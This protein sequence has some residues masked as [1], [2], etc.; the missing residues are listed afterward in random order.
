MKYRHYPVL[1]S[2]IALMIYLLCQPAAWAV[3]DTCPPFYLRTDTGE[4]INPMTGEN[5][6]QPFS[7]RQTCGA[8][9]DVDTISKGYHFMMDWDKAGD[10]RYA[11]TDTPW[12]VSTGLTGSLL[13][14]GFFQLAKKQNTHPDQID[15]SAFDFVARVPESK[16]GF[17]KPGCAACHAGGGLLEFD[18]DGQ[19]YDRRLA[20]N[21]ELAD[22]LDGDY[23]QS[24]W[25]KTGV[26]EPDCF[27]CHGS[28]YH[29]QKRIT[30]IKHL[31]FKWAG[32]AAAGIGQVH[33]R[34]S[35]GEVPVVVY[36]KRLFNEDGTFYLPDMVFRPEAKNCLICHESIEL[37]KRGN[38]WADPLNPDVHHLVGLTCIDCH[39]GDIRHN[40]AKGNAMDNQVAPELDN[41]MRSCRDCHTQ[42]YRGATRMRHDTIGKDHLDKLSCEACHIPALHRTAGG[43]MFLNTGIFGKYGQGDTSRFGTHKTWKP[44]YIIRAKDRDGIPRITPVNP[45]LNTLFTNLDEDGIYYPLFLS[46]VETAYNQSQQQMS[47]RE[48]PYDF[49]R[50]DDIVTML[51]TLAKTLAGNQRFSSVNPVFHTGGNLYFLKDGP[52]EKTAPESDSTSGP[53]SDSAPKPQD[54]RLLIREDTTWVSRLPFYSI[55]HNVAPADQALGSGGCRDCHAKDAHMFSGPVVTDYFGDNGRPVFVSMARFMGLAESVETVNRLFGLFLKT[56]PWVLGTGVLLILFAGIRLVFFSPSKSLDPAV[57]GLTSAGIFLV[58][59]FILAHGLLMMNTGFLRS[60]TLTLSGMAPWLGP[61]SAIIAAAGYFYLVYT[62]VFHGVVSFGLHVCGAGTVITGILLWI[63]QP[64]NSMSL[65]LISILHGI[66]AVATAGLLVYFLSIKRRDKGPGHALAHRNHQPNNQRDL[67]A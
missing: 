8:C 35:E 58:I 47:D 37:G 41:S 67:H 7:T 38:S 48:I 62:R 12:L 36:N 40:F 22:T 19:R 18:R 27:F 5:A 25:D 39:T 4:I 9:H 64:F 50:K 54:S 24:R 59:C 30:Q 3:T 11:G 26:I 43:A 45:M 1:G 2:L 17:Q 32:V 44:A 13:T 10:T 28:R 16:G 53:V 46:E 42:G 66:F 57:S 52:A 21:P 60:V 34:V 49:H 55:S 31:N 23:Y 65:V 20:E 29:I 51:E 56:G 61:L 15:L 14:Y 33:G 63:R 6:D